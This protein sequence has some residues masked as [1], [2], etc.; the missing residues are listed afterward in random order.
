MFIKRMS[1]LT[2]KAKEE[3]ERLRTEDRTTT[4]HLITVFTEVLQT[5][6]ETSDVTEAGT[7]IR[8]VLDNAGGTAHLLEQGEHVSA[9]HGDRY[10]PFVWR[11]YSSH[12]KAL[13]RVIK[14][15]DVRSTT[16]DQT[17][18]TAMN[19]LIAHEH[20]AKKYL[21]ATLDL[22]FASAKW[23]RTVIVRRK[24]KSWY[25]R[26]HLETCCRNYHNLNLTQ[27]C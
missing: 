26:Q 24:G 23:Q 15:L 22:S 4:E 5:N 11:F 27:P 18:M 21:E 13:F 2:T 9:H 3:L 7:L 16:S 8:T 14:T 6:T 1:K 10:Q 17:L 20:D 12:R 25:I 19:F